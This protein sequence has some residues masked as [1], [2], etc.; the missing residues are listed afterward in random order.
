LTSLPYEV[1]FPYGALFNSLPTADS[2]DHFF[3]AAMRHFLLTLW[4]QEDAATAVEYA[5]MLALILIAIIGAIGSVGAQTGGMW[6]DI[7]SDLITAGFGS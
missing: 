5:V 1:V 2:G 4:R 3:G 6:G 7:D